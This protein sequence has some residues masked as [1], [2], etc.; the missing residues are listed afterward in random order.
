MKFLGANPNVRLEGVEPLPGR[1]N[2]FVGNDPS[3]WR[4]NIRHYAKV[5]YEQVYPGID[6][7][8]YGNGK[9]LEHDFIVM[10]GADPATIRVEYEGVERLEIDEAGDLVLHTAAGEAR[11]QKPIVYQQAGGERE[12]IEGRYKLLGRN[13]VGFQ[14]DAD[15]GGGDVVSGNARFV[16]IF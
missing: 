7:V 2:Y 4:T 14:I 8:Y 9:R 15:R 10:P 1:S 16:G 12:R 6:V 5:R 11:Q 3:K 13:Q